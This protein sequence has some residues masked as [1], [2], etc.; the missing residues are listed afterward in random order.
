MS[1]LSSVVLVI[2]PREA[3]NS[4]DSPSS[5]TF[6]DIVWGCLTTIFACTWFSVHPNL[7]SPNQGWVK[8]TC[9][10]IG[11]MLMAV[12]APELIVFFAARQFLFS[13][14]FSKKFGVSITHG[15]FFAMGG[16]VSR[17]EI[18]HPIITL[19]QLEG[20][21]LRA[22]YLVDIR[23]VDAASIMDRSKGDALSKGVALMQ[24]FWFI[25]Q[26]VTRLSQHLPLTEIEVVTLA[27]AV[28][29]IFI[30]LLWWGKPLDAQTTIPIGPV[31]D[32]AEPEAAP[33]SSS[34]PMR[35]VLAA[36]Y[37]SEDY[38]PAS[39]N[40]VPL[41]WSPPM[42]PHFIPAFILETLAAVIFG[43]IHCSAWAAVFPSTV[44]K[45]LWRMCAV[46]VTAIPTLMG[47]AQMWT[48]S[49]VH[50]RLLTISLAGTLLL[51]ILFRILLIVLPFT[52]LRILSANDLIDVDWT[53]F[54]PHV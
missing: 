50:S 33:N 28:I 6:F 4:C 29:N 36:I 17:G 21:P 32:D 1:H 43:A 3:P 39:S 54:I 14:S 52:T 51:Y 5:R 38:N 8:L 40:C 25:I 49:A 18:G 15:F 44:E 19:K 53:A 16:F 35:W 22:K 2:R 47:L 37:G 13:R 9:R 48:N 41:L 7:P 30:W 24:S 11:M 20:P 26:C 34:R 27:F 31:V 42:Q 23:A 12:I 46:L 45:W 10:R